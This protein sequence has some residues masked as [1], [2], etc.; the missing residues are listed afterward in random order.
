[1]TLTNLTQGTKY[2]FYVESTESGNTATDNNAGNYYTFKTTQDTTPPT[3]TFTRATDVRN[4]TSASVDI[5]FITN[6]YAIGKVNY[7]TTDSY[8]SSETESNYNLNH[9]ITLSGLTPGQ[10]YHF[11]IQATDQ[12]SNTAS[13]ADY[14]FTTLQPTDTTPP[15]ISNLS[16]PVTTV[17]S[18]TAAISWTTNELANSL[19]D[20]GSTTGYGFTQGNSADSDTSH[21][22]TLVGL[23]PSTS[24]YFQAKSQD[25]AG[26]MASSPCATAFTT[27]QAPEPPPEGDTTPPTII[28][29]S[30]TGITN[31]T[32]SSAKISWTTD[33]TSDSTIGYSTSQGVFTFEQGSASLVTSHSVTLTNLSQN[34]TYYFRIKS[35]DQYGNLAI[36]DNAGNGYTFTTSS[37]ADTVPPIISQ[38][39]SSISITQATITW[40]TDENASSLVDYG[41]TTFYG[42]TSGNASERVT[43]H[44]VTLSGLTGQTKYYYRVR[45]ND[46]NSNQAIDDNNGAGYTFTTIS[47]TTAPTISNVTTA[48]IR[49]VSAVITWQTN[50]LATSQVAYGTAISYGSQTTEDTTLTIQHSVTITGLT[51]ETAYYYKVISKDL[52]GNSA[53]KAGENPFTT[54]KTP[55][56]V[57]ITGGGGGISIDAYPPLLTK[58]EV[59]NLTQSSATISWETSEGSSSLVTYGQTSEYGFLA[60]NHQERVKS[61][62]VILTNLNPGTIYHFQAIS[63]D[64]AGNRGQSDDLTLT[65]LGVAEVPPLVEEAAPLREEISQLFDKFSSAS[66][67]EVFNEIAE[68]MVS[69]PSIAGEYP[70]IEVS[71]TTAK[72]TWLTD[73]KANSLVA[74]TTEDKY[75]P[76]K[77]EPYSIISGYPD[78]MVTFHQVEIS[79]LEPATLY[80]Y[81]VRSKPLVGPVAESENKTFETL[82]LKLEISDITLQIVTESEVAISWRTNLPSATKIEYTNLRTGEKKELEDISYLREH[83][84]SLKGLES[85]TDYSFFIKAR[86]EMGSEAISPTLTFSTGKDIVPPE[87]SQVRT[88]VAISPRGDTVQ[89]IIIWLT[90][91]FSSSRVYYL[92]GVT[93]REEL[94]K[95]TPLD[96]TLVQKHTVVIPVLKPGQVYGFRVESIDPS[97]NVAISKDYTMLTPQQR[98]TIVQIMI[99]QFGQIFGWVKR[100][101][102]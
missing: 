15:T 79:G 64:S 2:Y 74:Y 14:T 53:E 75:D 102:I 95:S 27:S 84:I 58:V 92:E 63:Y 86:D 4:L 68:R 98:R 12:N 35:A 29:D 72:I 45:S 26:N 83:V 40:T 36:D 33:E 91:E 47:D 42:S 51:K 32:S 87:I 71:Q 39:S 96:K 20:Y 6:E 3:I 49:D 30:Q 18:S 9:L 66:I 77:D 7:G 28:F 22:V 60:G 78:E 25:A 11:Q 5:V 52:A 38:V 34:S 41:I 94:V 100:L 85:N 23:S 73:K 69:A 21:S 82:S 81:Q 17:T 93:W 54:T 70:Q 50:E 44:T 13:T 101:G 67:G 1:M 90:N 88:S 46:A 55:G 80:Y 99:S 65:T 76:T 31:I 89:T 56:E 19:V 10:N 62:K 24:Y 16:C 57:V 8:G 61:H 48:V 97:E 43:S 37:G 59:L